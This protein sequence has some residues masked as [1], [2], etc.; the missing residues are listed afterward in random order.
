MF[1]MPVIGLVPPVSVPVASKVSVVSNVLSEQ[2]TSTVNV[3]PVG[4]VPVTVL[5]T[6]NELG[7]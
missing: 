5:V 2:S 7:S 1:G 4:A 6:V 3:V